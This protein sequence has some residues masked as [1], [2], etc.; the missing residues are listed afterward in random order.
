MG[1]SINH[2]GSKTFSINKLEDNI[3]I[4]EGQ[5]DVISFNKLMKEMDIH[6]NA[7]GGLQ[8]YNMYAYCNN[9]PIKY[10]DYSGNSAIA[11]IA[12]VVLGIYLL[13]NLTSSE[14]QEPSEEEI[15]KAEEYA[16]SINGNPHDDR[17]TVDISFNAQDFLDNV[18][19]DAREY[20]YQRLYDNSIQT[21]KTH[22]IGTDNLM[23]VD[24]IRW[25][26]E[27]HLFA[28]KLDISNADDIDLNVEETRWSMIERGLK[29]L[30]Q[31]IKGWFVF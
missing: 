10:V 30:E 2:A 28:H 27:W 13:T 29:Y 8:G 25:E 23:D 5:E 11:V 9:N 18:D 15:Q 16:D 22:G 17:Q 21:A 1:A 6:I 3:I 7:N 19:E 31:N 14:K 12:L 24:H 26:T 4:V 20:F